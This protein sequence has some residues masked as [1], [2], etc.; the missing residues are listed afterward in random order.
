MNEEKNNDLFEEKTP[1]QCVEEITGLSRE[2]ISR[3]INNPAAKDKHGVRQ[4]L[5]LYLEHQK[6]YIQSRKHIR[7]I[8][9]K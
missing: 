1:R 9:I 8:K 5:I 3:I 2:T 4:E 6:K 7:T